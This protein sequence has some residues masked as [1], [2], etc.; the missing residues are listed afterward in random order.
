[1]E[2]FDSS[3]LR[4]SNLIFLRRSRNSKKFF[5]FLRYRSSIQQFSWVKRA[6][7]I[8]NSARARR[9]KL[10]SSETEQKVPYM[11]MISTQAISDI[12]RF[13]P[14]FNDLGVLVLATSRLG[15]RSGDS[16]W[17]LSLL[18]ELLTRTLRLVCL[19]NDNDETGNW[20]NCRSLF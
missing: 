11:N 4:M 3:E 10:T 20:H 16:S 2:C 7:A 18:C 5:S 9:H 12:E 1:M 17:R 13:F 14:P 15:N 19:S 6:K 8:T